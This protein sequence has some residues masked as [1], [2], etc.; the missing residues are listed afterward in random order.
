MYPKVGLVQLF[1]LDTDP[2]EL[3]NLAGSL[4]QARRLDRMLKHLDA[5]MR[6]VGDELE[7]PAGLSPAP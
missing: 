1:D 2:H 5:G 7:L 4:E 3:N 6:E